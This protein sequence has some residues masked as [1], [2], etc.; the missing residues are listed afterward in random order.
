[1]EYQVHRD[2]E[3]AYT[4]SAGLKGFDIFGQ[5]IGLTYKG[6][7][8]FQTRCGGL[9]SILIWI[10]IISKIW[11]EVSRMSET[12]T[13][14]E[15]VSFV[16]HYDYDEMLNPWVL[17]TSKYTI[18]GR[19]FTND[20]GSDVLESFDSRKIAR[21]QFYKVTNPIE[22]DDETVPPQEY[23]YVPAIYCKDKYAE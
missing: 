15:E 16:R 2:Q 4:K 6:E 5:P 7:A 8:T 12:Y 10:L 19:V 9:S 14:T 21:I 23:E 17:E 11:T 3:G 18:F 13:K 1:M 22:K 20:Y